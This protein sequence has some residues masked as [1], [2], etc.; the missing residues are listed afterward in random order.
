METTNNKCSQC[1]YN[2]NCIER[3]E[4]CPS[5]I[6]KY[7]VTDYIV[8]SEEVISNNIM[9]IGYG[10]PKIKSHLTIGNMVIHNTPPLQLV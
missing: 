9:K 3:P 6:D 4:N 5:F 8:A 10:F 2:D 1:I 7:S